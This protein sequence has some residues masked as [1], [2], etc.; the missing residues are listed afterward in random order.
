MD[1]PKNAADVAW[2]KFGAIPGQPGNAV[3]NG[4]YDTPTGRPAI[5]Y[6][7]KNLQIGDDVRVILSNNT[8]VNFV[9]ADKADIPDDTV[10]DENTNY[11]FSKKPGTNLNLI[12]CDGL[13][14]PTTKRYSKRIVIYTTLK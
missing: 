2:Y 3:I 1:V 4:H 5:F 14:N 8:V 6:N 13:W 12:T 10:A 11:I 7:L 9:V